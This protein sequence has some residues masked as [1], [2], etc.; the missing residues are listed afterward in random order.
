M[1]TEQKSCV[2]YNICMSEASFETIDFHLIFLVTI[3]I[4]DESN[5]SSGT[6]IQ[7]GTSKKHI[8][9][10]FKCKKITKIALKSWLNIDLGNILFVFPMDVK[11]LAKHIY[12]RPLVFTTNKCHCWQ[13]IVVC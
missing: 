13:I 10:R 12:K 1:N 9:L 4:H 3:P 11:I 2:Y 6:S 5:E 8:I 7:Q